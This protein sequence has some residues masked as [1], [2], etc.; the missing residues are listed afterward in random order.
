MLRLHILV[1]DQEWMSPRFMLPNFTCIIRIRL[2]YF[3][4]IWKV[5]SY[6]ILFYFHFCVRLCVAKCEGN[7]QKME[8]NW[9]Y[10]KAASRFLNVSINF[11]DIIESLKRDLKKGNINK[12][13]VGCGKINVKKGGGQNLERRNVERPI[14]RNFKITNIK[15]ILEYSIV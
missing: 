12:Y 3:E 8:A 10:G 2:K 13:F 1:V 5:E 11:Q 4:G 7:V 6:K 14:F 9:L 15:I